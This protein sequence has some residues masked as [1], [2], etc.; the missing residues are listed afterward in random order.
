MTF[1]S[2]NPEVSRAYN[3]NAAFVNPFLAELLGKEREDENNFTPSANIAEHADDFRIELAIPGIKKEEVKIEVDNRLL[4]ISG[5][6]KEEKVEGVN[7]SRKEFSYGKFKRTF[8]LPLTVDADNIAA[9]FE[10]GVLLL[11]VPKR[12]EAKPKPAREIM[13]A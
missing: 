8:R 12:E 10:N 6:R 1:V 13:I 3:R 2:C 5:E 4:T 11:I 7:Y 9:K